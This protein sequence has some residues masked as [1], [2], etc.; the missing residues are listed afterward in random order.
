MSKAE[1]LAPAGNL[2]KLKIAVLYGADAVYVGGQQYGLRQAADNFEVEELEEALDFAHS[3]GV[4]LYVTLNMIPHN[5]DL[6]GLKEYVNTLAELGV[7]AVIVAD[8]GVLSVVQKVAPELEIHLSTQANNVNWQ[9][10]NFW[11]KQGVKR[12]ILARELNLGEIKEINQRVEVDTE[13]F[14]HGAM[15]ISYSGRCLLSNYLVNRDSNRGQCAHS[16]RWNYSLVEEQRP[17]QYHPVFEDQSGTY[18]FNSKDLCMIEYIPEL[19]ATGL[20]SFKIEGRMKSINYVATVTNIY[21]QAIDTYLAAPGEYQ[22]QKEWLTELQ[23][24]SHRHYSTGFYLGEP[25]PAG[26]NYDS[27]AYLRNYD[28]MGLV[29]EYLPASQ[30]AVVEVRNKFFVND[31]VEFFGPETDTFTQPLEYIKNE[32]GELIVDAPHPH[33]LITIPV[34]QPVQKYD[35]LRREK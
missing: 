27:S 28:F 24:I 18:I 33:Q 14:I 7:D 1:L 5:Q 26:Q 34:S 6:V 29:Q 10:V 19:M 35:L 25:G 32:E 3:R 31:V 16:C 2:E 9:S 17:G 8:P 13:A 22:F 15:C 12:V 11:A 30:E 23:K 21:R 4:K 20:S